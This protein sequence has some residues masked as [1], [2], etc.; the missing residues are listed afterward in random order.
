MLIETSG[1]RL[2]HDEE[3]LNGFLEK[4]MENGLVLDGTVTNDSAKM[5]VSI[6]NI[7]FI[8]INI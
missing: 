4:T 7:M 2:D 5:R 1:S 3:K 6:W 8:Q